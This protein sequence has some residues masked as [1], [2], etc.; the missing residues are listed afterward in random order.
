ME[1]TLQ[2]Y[3]VMEEDVNDF[4]KLFMK[5]QD[6]NFKP[7]PL[8]DSDEEDRISSAA[9]IINNSRD[10]SEESLVDA[11]EQIMPYLQD[12]NKVYDLRNALKGA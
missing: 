5:Y 2:A 11:Y 1:R 6:L 8:F 4:V 3:Q 12:E 7:K 9:K 10:F